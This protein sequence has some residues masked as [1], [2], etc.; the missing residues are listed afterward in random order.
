MAVPVVSLVLA[1][2]KEGQNLEKSLGKVDTYL[3][4]LGVP[5]EIIM[6][7]DKSPDNTLQ[8]AKKFAEGKDYVKLLAHQRNQGRGQTV[9]DGIA[10]ARGKVAGFID[11][12]LEVSPVFIAQM[13][14]P[15][16]DRQA[17]VTIGKR[18]YDVHLATFHR[19]IL[20]R[21]YIRFIKRVL[22]LPFSDTEAGYKFF[23]RKKIGKVLEACKDK[24][25]FFD[26]EVV[27]KSYFAG[28]RVREV[29]VLFIRNVEKKSTVSPIK[30]SIKYLVRLYNFRKSL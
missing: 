9:K 10:V 14:E 8:I 21:G 18:I 6:V 2:Y 24:G 11:V 4:Q 17:E 15:I 23:D 13:I 16:L 26:T 5:Y 7:E 22:G 30:D 19:F 1:L 27:A 20:S 3:R 28:L 25:W 29:P 12:D